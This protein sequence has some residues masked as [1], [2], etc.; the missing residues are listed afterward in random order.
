MALPLRG[1]MREL[2]TSA[3]WL[4]MCKNLTILDPDG[5]D[6]ENYQYSFNEELIDIGE[7]CQRLTESTI[8]IGE[9]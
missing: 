3:E 8:E 9:K 6:R 1:Y 5:W 2:K 4:K 7:F